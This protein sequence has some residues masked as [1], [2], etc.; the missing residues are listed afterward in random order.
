MD[1]EIDRLKKQIRENERIWSGFR[2]IELDMVG[3]HSLRELIA[4]VVNA[5]PRRFPGVDRVTLACVDPEYELA[6]LL[7]R[8]AGRATFDPRAFVCVPSPE[9][10]MRLFPK[11]FAP[12]LGQ[13]DGETLAWLF[14]Q[15]TPPASVALAP[16][17]LRG[18]L[19]GSFNQGSYDP[20]HFTPDTATDL[21]EHLS[22]I[23]ALCIDNALSHERLKLDGLTDPLTRVANRRFF[24]RRL[25]EEAQRWARARAPLAC[26]LVDID[27]FKQINDRHGHQAGD[28]ILRQV[29]MLL[30]RDLRASD[31]LARYGGEEFVLLLPDT[32]EAQARAIAERIRSRIAQ[33]TFRTPAGQTLA[34]TVSAGVAVLDTAAAAPKA[35]AGEW[36]LRRADGALYR[37][38]QEGRNRVECAGND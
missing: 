8:D 37:A 23:I 31:V 1:L 9:P 27:H 33:T 22:A 28:A 13:I 5:V 6:R 25:G 20:R 17:A 10:L 18:Q 2:R 24:E 26:M 38:K 14:P 32:T 3:A 30:G 36:L 19:I 34:V 35:S 21:L 7:E 29:A 16:L 11:P 12:R 15:A 4:V